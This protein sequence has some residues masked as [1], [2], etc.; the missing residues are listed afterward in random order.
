MSIVAPILVIIAFPVGLVLTMLTL[1]GVWFILIA[2]LIAQWVHRQSVTADL[3]SWWTLGICTGVAVFGEVFDLLASS[4][5]AK[6]AGSSRSGAIGALIGSIA[7]AIIGIPFAPP[8]GPIA[9]AVLGAALGAFIAERMIANKGWKASSLVAAGAAGG[10][11]ACIV[12]KLV[13]TLGVGGTLIA[14]CLM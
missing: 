6:A 8:I 11:L 9:F 12:V 14:A 7:G 1:P 4:A 5:G 2:A 10:K 3:M 13:I